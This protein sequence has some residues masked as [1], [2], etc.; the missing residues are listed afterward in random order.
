M[1]GYI[2]A[3]NVSRNTGVSHPPQIKETRLEHWTK[4]VFLHTFTTTR[5]WFG[6]ESPW[7]YEGNGETHNDDDVRS[8]DLLLSVCVKIG[9]G[10]R[11]VYLSWKD[12]VGRGSTGW[13]TDVDVPTRVD[14]GRT[15]S[16]RLEGSTEYL[17]PQSSV[18]QNFINAS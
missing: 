4:P 8:D 11:S 13:L 3:G 2:V 5:S 15:G 12:L 14:C 18:T 10:W 16:S 7:K 9:V 6:S 17:H 1:E